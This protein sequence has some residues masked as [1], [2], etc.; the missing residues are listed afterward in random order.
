[1][2]LPSFSK[3]PKRKWK[4]RTLNALANRKSNLLQ[5]W[6][7]WAI[8]CLTIAS[9]CCSCFASLWKTIY[10]KTRQLLNKIHVKKS[11]AS[12]GQTKRKKRSESQNFAR[13]ESDEVQLESLLKRTCVSNR[14]FRFREKKMSNASDTLIATDDVCASRF[15]SV[16]SYVYVALKMHG[17]SPASLKS[18]C[19]RLFHIGFWIDTSQRRR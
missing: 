9:H 11:H 17:Q 10:S 13:C 8:R 16:F 14:C 4:A 19:P 18:V 15:S 2:T 6:L 12:L 1:M 5:P 3:D 7:G